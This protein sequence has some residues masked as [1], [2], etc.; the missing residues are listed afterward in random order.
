MIKGN[1]KIFRTDQAVATH[2]KEEE[3]RRKERR[4]YQRV[5]K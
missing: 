3:I 1:I 5:G 4:E 2:Y